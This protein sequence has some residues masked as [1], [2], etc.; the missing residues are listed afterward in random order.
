VKEVVM[1][2]VNGKVV[3]VPAAGI[4]GSDLIREAR[5]PAGRRAVIRMRGVQFEGVDPYRLYSKVE[6]LDKWNNPVKMQTIP[7]RAKGVSYGG[8]RTELSQ[9]LITEQVY[10][11]AEHYL[12][13]GVEFDEFNADW[14]VA[15]RYKLPDA[16][17]SIAR[18]SPL[19]IVFPT[20]YPT[21]PPIGFYLRATLGQSPDGRLYSNAFHDA[22]KDPIK[23][24]WMWYCVYVKPECW[25]PARYVY[26][27]D[28]KRGDNLWTYLILINEALGNQG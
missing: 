8:P 22:C 5:V 24:G 2:T 15:P 6:L 10:D 14:M 21:I 12:K 9:K 3:S 16:W 19:L 11:V 18:F 20:E 25:S 23:E 17:E 13:G 4:Y 27:G 28:W 7:D 26:P 1:A